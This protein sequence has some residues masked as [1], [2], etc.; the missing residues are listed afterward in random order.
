MGLSASE[1]RDLLSRLGH[2]FRDA[3]LFDE[4]LRHASYTNENPNAGPSNQR[5]EFLGDA[6][7]GLVV[8]EALVRTYPDAREGELTRYRAALVSERS[9][10]RT[11]RELGLESALKLG[12]GE[13]AQRSRLR[14]SL[15]A[16]SLEA[17]V[18]AA[19]LDGGL[20]AARSVV[21]AV[22]GERIR[23]VAAESQQD[24]KS[25]LQEL[26]QSEGL[27]DL[28]YVVT[29]ETGPDH[30]KRFEVV[31]RRGARE[32]GRGAGTSKK[33]AEQAAAEDALA[34]AEEGP[35]G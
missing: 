35:S 20:D 16:D 28:E 31:V 6:V 14:A 27:A 2:G 33:A 5:L 34:R 17:I 32:L 19:F 13:A 22:L 26:V 24:H 30:E 15:L 10:S 7:L 25:L 29:A 23:R 1:Q 12:K 9:L 3:D 8:A 21:Q 18:G 11:A 4:A